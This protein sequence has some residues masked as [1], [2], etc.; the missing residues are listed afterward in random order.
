MH[1]EVIMADELK[2]EQ[3]DLIQMVQRGRMAHDAQA[4]PSQMTGVYWLEAKPLGSYPVPTAR[5]GEWRIPTS[6]AAMD[7]LWARIKA[8][9]EAGELGYKAKI[10]TT[11]AHGQADA[12]ARMIVVRTVDADD[13]ADV[14]RVRAA[15]RALGIDAEITYT[16][17]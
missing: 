10:S 7:A 14:E 2:Q 4:Q 11:P 6:T 1:K 9:T 3:L 13:T 16:R 15:L 17:V 5:A 8:A 12:D